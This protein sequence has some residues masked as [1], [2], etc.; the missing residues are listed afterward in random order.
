MGQYEERLKLLEKYYTGIQSSYG[1]EMKGNIAARKMENAIK[2][3]A[4]DLDRESVLGFYDTTVTGNG[5]NGYIFTD[6]MVYYLE[7][8]DTPRKLRYEDIED[9]ELIDMGKK[10]GDNKLRFQMRDGSEVIWTNC[11]LNKTPLYHFFKDL[12]DCG[13][14]ASAGTKEQVSH[15]ESRKYEGAVAGGIAVAAHGQVN[16][17]YEEE[18]FH[19]RQ[20]HGFAAERANTLYDRLTGHDAKI[21][22]DDNIKNGADRIVDGVAI[23]SKYCKSGSACVNECFDKEGNFRYWVD[24]KPMQ[25]EVPSDK[26][27]AAVKA[28]EE[29]IRE[30]KMPGI[31][32]PEEAK[33]IVR[34]GHFT[35]EQAKNIAK[36]GT[37]ESLTY[38]AVNGAII[39]TSAFGV[40]AVITLAV[41]LWSG[42]DFNSSIKAATYSGLKV[43]GTAFVT[44]IIASQLSKAGLNSALVGSSEVIVAFMGPKAS[45][46]LINAFRSGSKIYGAAAMKSAAKLLR[47]NVI[48]AGVTVVVLSSFDIA[49]IF[50]GRI[51]GKQL[52][53]NLANTASTVAGGTGGWLGGAA[54]G[55]AILPGVG[56]IVGGLIGSI[57]GGAAAGKATGAVLNNFIE[58]DADEMVGIIQKE[59][60]EL[61]QDYLLNQK[62]AEKIVE[63]L[64]R[65][66]DGKMLKDM[67]ASSHRKKFAR[68]LL[69]PLIEKEIKKRKR[70]RAVSD[71]QMA[72]GL[73][74]VL[75]EISDSI[76]RAP[77]GDSTMPV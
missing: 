66:L 49:N 47:G 75:E 46:V 4:P 14:A 37:V 19:G 25:I 29:K 9:V 7:I 30:G 26:Y 76:D 62:E 55:S 23:Q 54:V 71:K 5:K 53:K 22:G 41:N 40:T 3:F 43:G 68:Q 13:D 65:K 36:A 20:G 34:K 6:T 33:N 61:A 72:K 8:L 1:F 32:D 77:T 60:E 35:Y 57:A 45:A 70:I 17:S 2:K 52:F 44:T 63:E 69:E 28:M 11:G 48:T 50:R 42:E 39:A 24:G 21:V 74:E 27:D 16:K 67:F 58:D 18:K 38:D 15:E 59:F 73:K 10:D 51:S 31:T 64:S 56:T 12:L